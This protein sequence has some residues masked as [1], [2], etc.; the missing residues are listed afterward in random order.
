LTQSI[1]KDENGNDIGPSL[2]EFR[3][4]RNVGSG[5]YAVVKL[6]SHELTKKRVALKIYSAS[7]N[8]APVKR[9]AIWQEI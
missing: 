1:G 6:A 9:K 7:Q 5:A 3:I 2:E 4:Q 8:M